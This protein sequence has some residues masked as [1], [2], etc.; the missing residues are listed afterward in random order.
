MIKNT[1][2]SVVLVSTTILCVPPSV[3]SVFDCT[4]TRLKDAKSFMEFVEDGWSF[5]ESEEEKNEAPPS[6]IDW[7]QF[8][9]IFRECD[10]AVSAETNHNQLR[11]IQASLERR[12]NRL[13]AVQRELFS[14]ARR[15]DP[16]YTE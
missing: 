3:Q 11:R 8:E 10:K 14:L 4:D 7:R 6:A 5:V 16:E 9:H 13:H 12:K 2:L 1:V 15:T